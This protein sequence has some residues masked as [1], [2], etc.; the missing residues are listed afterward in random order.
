ML[1]DIPTATRLLSVVVL[2]AGLASKDARTQ[3]T[4]GTPR[5]L[6]GPMIGAADTQSARIWMRLSDTVE[7]TIAISDHPDLSHARL[8]SPVIASVERDRCVEV[9]IEGLEAGQT[10]YWEPRIEGEKDKYLAGFPPFTLSL[11]APGPGRSTVAF[12]SCARI[13]SDPEQPIWRAIER[14]A[15]DVF[16]WLGDNI[17]ADSR[18]P[19]VIAEEYRRQRDVP[20][21]QGLLRSVPQLAV[22]DDHDY[23]LNNHDRTNPIR[24]EALE[25]F[26]RY[27]ANPSYGTDST[28]GI[29][30]RWH[31]AGVDY[32][33]VDVRY[34]RDPN[35]QADG[36]D[37][38]MLGSG[39]LEWLKAGLRESRTPFKMLVGGSGWSAAKGEGGDSWAAFLQERDALFD[40][41]TAEE[42]EGVVLVSGDT[43]VGEL[44]CIPWSERG[45][46][47]LYDL[48]SSP[49]A[50][51]PGSSWINRSPEVRIRS[52]YGAGTNFGRIDF[53]LEREDPQL[54]FTL[55]GADGRA[56]WRPLVLHASE[57]RPGVRTWDKKI[58]KA[59]MDR[60]SR[61][62]RRD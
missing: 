46:Y 11:P 61:N 47:D 28:P 13:Q 22:W 52:V 26:R 20:N 29:F 59:E 24:A 48:V 58:S 37:K 39:Q 45:G 10:Y 50:Q 25:V 32:F 41:I 15:P 12:G 23:G 60:R 17:Y 62:Q 35:D 55:F 54:T 6:Q 53:D 34:H 9:V 33:F 44:N 42:I 16:L 18:D 8:A 43:H 31:L 14:Q 7:A 56:V 5:I 40:W 1:R 57:L 36:P 27:W 21:L 3:S 49:L 4:R 38:T 19:G 30:F 2:A 51:T